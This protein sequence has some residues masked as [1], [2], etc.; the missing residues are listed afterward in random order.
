MRAPVTNRP[1]RVFL[2]LLALA[3]SGC[4]YTTR[5]GLAPHLKTVYVKPFTN[6]IDITQ[7][8]TGN[9]RFPIYRHQMEVDLTNAVID[10]YQ[11]TGLLRP[12]SAERADCRLE[13][14]LVEFRRDA[15]RYNASQQVEEWRLS[16]VVNLRFYD[17]NAKTLLWEE[18][19][20]T[21][22]STYFALGTNAESEAAALARATTDLA[23]RMV[24]RTVESW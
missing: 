8:T 23:R 9:E 21:G 12:A 7:L 1:R 5:P 6:K 10:R 20:F 15:L 14:D 16:L 13:G 3:V 11:F 19:R 17:Q 22:D 18:V 24:E 4:G 2:L